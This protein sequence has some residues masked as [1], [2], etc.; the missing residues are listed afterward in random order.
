MSRISVIIPTKN[1]Q[2]YCEAAIRQI[3]SLKINNLEIIIQ[4]NSDNDD[5]RVFCEKQ[6]SP[7]LIYHY[8]PGVLSF[9]DNFSEAIGL[10]NGDWLCM[11]GDDDCILPNITDVVDLADEKHYDAV[12]PALSSVYIWPNEKPF[13]KG[14]ENGYLCIS[15]LKDEWRHVDTYAGLKDLL[16]KGGQDYQKLSIPRLYHGLVSRQA[17][18]RVKTISGHFFEGLTPDIYMSTVLCYCC[19]NVAR[20]SFPITVSGI[21]K[22]SGSDNSATG[23]HTGDLKNA[24]HFAG[25]DSY[26]WSSRVPYIYTVETIWG[27]TVLQALEKTGRGDENLFNVSFLDGLCWS[28]YPQFRHVIEEHMR[29]WHIS[30]AKAV[31]LALLRSIQTNATRVTR[32]FRFG[33]PFKCFDVPNIEDAY[34]K[35]LSY[36]EQKIR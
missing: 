31:L 16:N 5:L 15:H 27:E 17:V 18:E 35:T 20:V 2:F 6:D 34:K 8:H 21:C 36:M 22:G 14:A 7:S 25:H 32:R 28:K 33:K 11:I 1:R 9:V 3:L 24:P 26:N 30:K 19:S 13:V 23:K 10:C 12:I 4:D 29:C